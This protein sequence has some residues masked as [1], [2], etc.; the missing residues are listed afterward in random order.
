MLCGLHSLVARVGA[1]AVLLIG[2]AGCMRTGFGFS[3]SDRRD[4]VKDTIAPVVAI[5]SPGSGSFANSATAAAFPIS[6]R[7]VTDILRAPLVP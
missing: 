6:G 4:F 7:P 1:G 3:V 5:T 2:S